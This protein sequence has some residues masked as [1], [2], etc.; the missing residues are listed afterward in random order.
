M[1]TLPIGINRVSAIPVKIPMTFF[2]EVEKKA[3]Y[4][5][6]ETTKHLE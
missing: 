2:T 5:S 1:S 4:N 3:T 6:Q